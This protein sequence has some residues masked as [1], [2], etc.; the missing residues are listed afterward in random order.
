MT[1]HFAPLILKVNS[2]RFGCSARAEEIR[3]QNA[4]FSQTIANGQRHM[5]SGYACPRKMAAPCL[6]D[7]EPKAA[8]NSPLA[9]RELFGTPTSVGYPKTARIL[10]AA[11]FRSAYNQG[12]RYTSRYFAAFCLRVARA[13]GE[14]PRLGFTLPRA[15]GKAVLRNRVKRQ[16]AGSAARALVRNVPGMGYCDQSAASRNRG[17]GGGA[18]TGSGS[19]GGAMQKAVIA[20]LASLQTFRVAGF[21]VGL[22]VFAHLFGVHDGSGGSLRRPAG[23]R[24]G[25]APSAALPSIPRGRIRSGALENLNHGRQPTPIE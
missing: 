2:L 13:E 19:V 6:R 23:R 21:A 15:F 5:D 24:D 14:G 12:T 1:P 3:C 16:A 9:T 4:P 17:A 20:T 22:P 18:S 25:T 7:A 11:D 8:T 10:R